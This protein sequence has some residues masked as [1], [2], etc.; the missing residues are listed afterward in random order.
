[1]KQKQFNK[2]LVLNKSTI[3][4]LKIDEMDGAKGG[5]YYTALNRTCNTWCNCTTNFWYLC[6][7]DPNFDDECALLP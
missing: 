1:M 4:N 6:P 2:K 3:A 5:I 7:T